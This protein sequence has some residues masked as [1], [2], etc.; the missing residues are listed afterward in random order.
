MN[1]ILQI[2]WREF[3][4]T[5]MTKGFLIGIGLP[6]LL[7]GLSAAL[8]PW[9]IKHEK[10]FTLEG[11]VVVIDA[12]G[13]V[14]S[15]LRAYLTP[16]AFA[17]RRRELLQKTNALM[18][19][20]VRR[21]AAAQG[22]GN[23]ALHAD[24]QEAMGQLPQLTVVELP[25][26]TDIAAAKASLY[27][28]EG[29]LAG[30]IALLH[31]S[32][33]AVESPIG[34]VAELGGYELYVRDRLDERVVDE[35]RDAVHQ[36]I[37]EARMTSR[38]LDSRE[39]HTLNH[40]ERAEARKIGANGETKD[41]EIA[42]RLM[43]MAF[44]FLIFIAVLTAGQYLM[45]STIEEKS[46]RVVE[47]LLAAVSPVQLMAGKILGQLAVGLLML[48]VYAGLGVLGLL[49]LALI[50]LLAP[51]QLL[52]LLLFFLI[53]FV[54]QAALMA[55]IGAAVNELRE[56]QTLLTPMMLI[57][58]APMMLLQPI[59]RDPNGTMATVLS[60]LPPVSPYVM[61]MRISSSNP[62]PGWQVG[63][64]V[65]LGFGAVA[66]TIWM[67]GKVFRIGMLMHG[68]PPNLATLWRWVR[69]A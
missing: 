36:S 10:A 25:A 57:M 49:S 59:S 2:A 44:M 68:K 69:M 38:H 62:P 24:I 55:A 63:L 6:P 43:P 30:R 67:A 4:A 41:N 14:A 33:D 46:S 26:D 52:Y 54:T 48:T 32:K 53:A 47:V 60:L 15:G 34:E 65:L 39:I 11:D 21:V 42:A 61:V 50:G 45:T 66:A 35:L 27:P 5:V 13:A 28:G 19:E 31:I 37:V 3:L 56:A 17:A 23:P 20:A 9:I 29:V 16:E 22:A 58:V 1:K 51:A 40:V 64:A 12:S 8:V 18:P 7:L